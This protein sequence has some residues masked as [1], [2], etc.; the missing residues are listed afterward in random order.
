MGERRGFAQGLLEAG[1][2]GV[3][4]GYDH[5][6]AADRLTGAEMQALLFGRAYR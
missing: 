5:V 2:V 3:P 6:S 4:G 1:Q